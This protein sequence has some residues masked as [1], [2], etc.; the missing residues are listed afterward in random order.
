MV[1]PLPLIAYDT[2]AEQT[3]ALYRDGYAYLPGVLT[4]DQVAKLRDQMD[5][6]TPISES[7]DKNGRPE[8][9]GF[10]NKHINNAFNRHSHFCNFSTA[11]V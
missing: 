3:E 9:I 4:S 1:D 7:F 11:P 8:D 2:L 5:A 6:L 10:I